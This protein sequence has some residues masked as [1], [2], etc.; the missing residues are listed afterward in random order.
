MD[1]VDRGILEALQENA[2]LSIA[3]VAEKV[4][5]SPTPCWRRIQKLEER[6][7]I[8]K[9]VALLE[10]KQVNLGLTVFISVRTNHHKI[11][12]F[13]SF[14]QLVNAMPEVVEFYRVTGN[15]DYLIK[16][17]V[18]SIEGYDKVYKTLIKGAELA[19]VSSMFAMEQI[20]YTTA[21]PLDQAL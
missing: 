8:R 2:E 5:L 16:V 3:D 10:P 18:S 17:M 12:W 14:Y 15:T 19:D 6:G 4:G 20:K 9:R 7:V 11:E 13:E 1:R 21:L